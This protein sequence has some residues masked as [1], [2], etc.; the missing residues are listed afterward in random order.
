MAGSSEKT[1][2]AQEALKAKG[3]DPGST[4]GAMDA[5]T[6]QALRDFQKANKLPVTGVL[7]AKTAQQLGIAMESEQR[8]LP[9]SGST[10]SQPGITGG[11][12]NSS[13]R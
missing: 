7:D 9:Q 1:K 12:P 3:F 4:S 13:T 10:P 6:Q 8:S 2:Q 5:K 11:T